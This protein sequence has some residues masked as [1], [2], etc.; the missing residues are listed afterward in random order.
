MKNIR[1]AL[2][3]SALLVFL[4]TTITAEATGPLYKT[5]TASRIT[6]KFLTGVINIPMCFM[7]IPKQINRNIQNTDPFTGTI[8][9]LGEGSLDTVKRL[10]YGVF[11]VFTCPAPD[12]DT[13]D[14][15]VESPIPYED[16]AQ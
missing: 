9:G 6:N 3:I 8:T 7:E 15:W 10:G 14:H 2:V 1:T 12:L 5:T 11:E 13:L 16:L 4:L